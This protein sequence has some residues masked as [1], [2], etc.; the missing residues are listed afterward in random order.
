MLPNKAQGNPR[1]AAFLFLR[2]LGIWILYSAVDSVYV[3]LTELA[4]LFFPANFVDHFSAF[5]AYQVFVPLAAKV[6][7]AA[8]FILGAP[9]FLKWATRGRP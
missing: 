5:D 4:K 3:V 2:G 8:W 9:P 7:L 6:L 1:F